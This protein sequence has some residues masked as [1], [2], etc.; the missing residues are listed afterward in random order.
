MRLSEFLTPDRILVP[1]R[2]ATIEDATGALVQ[3]LIDAGAVADPQ[4]LRE[5][6]DAT[7]GEDLVAMGDR[8]FLLHYRTDAVKKLSVVL[9]TSP[10]PMTREL[11]DDEQQQ[12]RIA[13]LVVAPPRQAARYLQL[14]G[15]FARVLSKPANVERILEAATAEAL[16]KIEV[17]YEYRVPEE[18]TVRDLMSDRPRFI[19]AD[20]ALAT[21]ARDMIRLKVGALPVVDE[22]GTVIGMFSQ[23]EIMRHLLS[24]NF[25]EGGLGKFGPPGAP[26]KRTVRD[27]MTRQVL[28]V[29]PD[30]PLAEVASMMTN[31][32]VERVPVV[33]DGRLVGL[34]TRGDVVRKLIGP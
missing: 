5:R 20:T 28:C 34:L 24:S 7:R 16:A 10:T 31:R 12:A 6:A 17:L 21:A 32:D 25:Q 27:V 3:R 11:G 29:S 4:K 2:A 1:L 18:L 13:L 9:G 19:A 26:A 14:V 15:A 8:A 22:S 33:R 30:Q 23:R